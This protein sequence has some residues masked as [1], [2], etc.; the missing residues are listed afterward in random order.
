MSLNIEAIEKSSEN[1]VRVLGVLMKE[2]IGFEEIVDF[3][4]VFLSWLMNKDMQIFRK[5]LANSLILVELRE[6]EEN[7]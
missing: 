2:K 5:I 6:A 4:T 1:A 7:A 3:V